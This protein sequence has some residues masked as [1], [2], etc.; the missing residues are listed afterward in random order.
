MCRREVVTLEEATSL[1]GSLVKYVGDNKVEEWE[2]QAAMAQ[3]LAGLLQ[4][5][6]ALVR[7]VH[8]LC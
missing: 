5:K 2:E 7:Q 1:L 3:E 4:E 8:Q 6:L